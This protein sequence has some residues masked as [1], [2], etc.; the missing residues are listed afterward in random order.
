MLAWSN[1][2][3]LAMIMREF[4]QRNDE[5]INQIVCRYAR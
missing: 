3:I 5:I 1:T 4:I 2:Y